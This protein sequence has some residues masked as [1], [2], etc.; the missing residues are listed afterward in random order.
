MAEETEL[1]RL[2]NQNKRKRTQGASEGPPHKKQ[3]V[4]VFQLF[5]SII[6]KLRWFNTPGKRN[7][8]TRREGQLRPD[9]RVKL[10]WKFHYCCAHMTPSS[11]L[12]RPKNTTPSEPAFSWTKATKEVFSLYFYLLPIIFAAICVYYLYPFISER[13]STTEALVTSSAVCLCFLLSTLSHPQV[14]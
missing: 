8:G 5:T 12:T 4:G 3:K 1:R 9:A 2:E 7:K 10:P 14:S 11:K 6:N 13:Y